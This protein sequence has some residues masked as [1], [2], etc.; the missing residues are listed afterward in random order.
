MPLPHELIR[1]AS[2]FV[3]K[4]A[5]IGADLARDALIYGT[6]G[7]LGGAAISHG[8]S[9]DVAEPK[10]RRKIVLRG[11][12]RGA[13]LGALGGV[14]ARAAHAAA[15]PIALKSTNAAW[16]QAN[17]LYQKADAVWSD[18]SI[19][20][21]ERHKLWDQA[22]GRKEEVRRRYERIRDSLRA[23]VDAGALGADIAGFG[24]IAKK[25]RDDAE[26]AKTKI[27]E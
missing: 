24:Y 25:T 26:K 23:G 16:N 14:L 22:T 20:T 9:R 27:K 2:T 12:A 6:I 21:E 15:H 1:A 11:A 5:G 4:E 13:S 19:P 3:V 8:G 17:Q 18:R 10:E 7:G